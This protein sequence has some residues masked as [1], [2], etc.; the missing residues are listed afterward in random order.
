[1][2][3]KHNNE[4]L[5][6]YCGVAIAKIVISGTNWYMQQYTPIAGQQVK[7]SEQILTRARTD[8]Y[9]RKSFCFH[10]GSKLSV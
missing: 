5:N 2:E 4:V 6:G 8:S 10:D 3:R 9:Y 1:M 7:L